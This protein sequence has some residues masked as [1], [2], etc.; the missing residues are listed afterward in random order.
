MYT[1]SV[2][3]S[4]EIAMTKRG[5]FRRANC[6][7]PPLKLNFKNATSPKLSS[8]KTLKLINGCNLGVYNDQ[9]ILKEY[10]VY[11]IYNLFTDKS[12]KVRLV[13]MKYENSNGKKKIIAMHSFF[14]EDIDA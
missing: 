8:L 13:N 11:K 7:V 2:L 10:L 4:E 14:L 9:L 1:D 3:I 6:Y 12:F 5:L